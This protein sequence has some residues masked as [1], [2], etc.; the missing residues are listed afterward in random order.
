MHALIVGNL[1]LLLRRQ[2]A[3]GIDHKA[4]R[5]QGVV[6]HGHLHLVAKNLPHHRPRKLTA[7]DL[8]LLGHQGIASQGVV[9]LP[10]GQGTHPPRRRVHHPQTGPVALA[11]DHALVVGGGDFAPLQHQG[12]VGVKDQLGVVERAPIAFVHPQHHHHG[13]GSRRSADCIGHRPWY[14]DRFF[15][16]PQ[17]RFTHQHRGLHKGEIRVVGNQGFWK[18]NQLNPSLGGLGYGLQYLVGGAVAAKQHGADLG[19]SGADGLGVVHGR[20]WWEE[21]CVGWYRLCPSHRWVGC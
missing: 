15:V 5:L 6:A 9:V 17:V 14:R 3:G 1:V 12:A 16:Q 11:P 4:A 2:P 18:D 8:L 19:G 13:V 7:V 20:W 21:S 10:A